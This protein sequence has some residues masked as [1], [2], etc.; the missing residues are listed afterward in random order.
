MLEHLGQRIFLVTARGKTWVG[1][2]FRV[3]R[4]ARAG[5]IPPGEPMEWLSLILLIEG[6]PDYPKDGLSVYEED[7]GIIGNEGAWSC[8]YSTVVGP[9]TRMVELS[10]MPSA[11]RDKT[12][13]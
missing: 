1:W 10:T 9:D 5:T 8:R 7:T 2:G 3:T 4:T 12:G 11:A 13:G 6:N